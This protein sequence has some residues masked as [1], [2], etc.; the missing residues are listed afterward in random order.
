[1]P[2]MPYFYFRPEIRRKRRV[3]RP[4]FPARRGNVSDSVINKGYI[5]CFSARMRETA[6]FLLPV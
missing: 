6:L 2:K 1:M 5:A 4:R 3:P